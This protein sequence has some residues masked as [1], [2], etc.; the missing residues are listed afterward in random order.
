MARRKRAKQTRFAED[1][2]DKKGPLP[3]SEAEIEEFRAKFQA[4][5][6]R[7]AEEYSEGVCTGLTG[8]RRSAAFRAAADFCPHERA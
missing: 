6:E 2:D 1:A 4:R 3:L 8:S 5:S 7:W